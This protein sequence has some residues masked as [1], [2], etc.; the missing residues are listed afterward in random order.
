[1]TVNQGVSKEVEAREQSTM[2]AGR[3]MPSNDSLDLARD[4]RAQTIP[5]LTS[6]FRFLPSDL[7]RMTDDNSER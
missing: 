4:P 7:V 1:M 6:S 2:G 5:F 3:V